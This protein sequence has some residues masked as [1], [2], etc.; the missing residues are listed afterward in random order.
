MPRKQQTDHAVKLQKAF[1]RWDD[2]HV[3]G[4]NDPGWP[5]GVNLNLVRNHVLYYRRQIEENLNLF[6]YPEIYNRE[7]PPKVAQSYMAR[8]DEIRAAA[9]ASLEAY[10]ADPDYQY[11]LAHHDEIP[12]KMQKKLC[13]SA[14][15]GYATRLE[16]A[17][18]E[19]D[20][21]A[22]R[23]HN[24]PDSYLSIFESCAQG[25]RDFVAGS[26]DAAAVQAP[27]EPED[28]GFDD[29]LNEGYGED[30]E[31]DPEQE[32]GGMTMKMQ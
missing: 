5:D 23:R 32:F 29:E 20:L 27:D 4:C 16:R 6:G 18:A 26:L 14:I 31:E 30:F 11:I 3:N 9:G 1:D 28:E 21:I 7:V 22:M 19:D 15:V 13:I 12:E 25:M 2:I 8:P 24:C 10:Q 17:I